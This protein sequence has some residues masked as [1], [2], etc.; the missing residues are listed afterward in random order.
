MPMDGLTIGAAVREINARVAGGR[1]DKINQP[2]EDEIV[3]FIRSGGENYKL[4]LCTNASFARLNL[5]KI[6]K[7]NPLTP[8]S[9]CMLLRKHLTGA[10]VLGLNQDE[11]ERLVRV[12]T[13]VLNDFQEPE[14]RTLILEI[15]GKYS[16]LIFLDGSGRILD[17]IRRVNSLMSR[18]RLIQPGLAYE[19]PPSQGK[20]NPFTADLPH[21]PQAARLL[22]DQYMGLS[23]QAAEEISFRLNESGDGFSAYL[24]Q[25]A[26][27]P[28]DPVLQ[29][30]E[31][32]DP[33]DFFAFPQKRFLPEFQQKRATLSEAI[34]D[35]F[36]L[37]DK[38]CR[39]KERS[40]ELRAKLTGLLEKAE[41]KCAQQEEKLRECADV[42]K[43]RVWGELITANLYQV[44]RGADKTVLPNYYEDMAMTEIPL[45]PALAPNVN[46]QKY[47]KQYNKLKTAAR[48]LTEQRQENEKEIEFFT[49]LLENL[50]NCEND[51]DIAQIRRELTEAGY[52]KAP[53]GKSKP[54]E[55]KPMHF[56]SHD[57][58]DIFVGKNNVQNDELTLRF[59]RPDDLWLHVKEVHGS[60][61]I[62]RSADPDDQ[63]KEE[64]AKLAV[65]YSKG[66]AGEQI[67]VDTA[68]RKFVKKPAGALPGKVI[69]TNQ[70]TYYITVTES[71]IKKILRKE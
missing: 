47:F 14:K 65:W 7:A 45:D 4:L 10:K 19:L 9:F 30:D 55:S 17:A 61:V 18:V 29:V 13:E 1:I 6:Q 46:A 21:S 67:P 8:P 35:Y 68:K 28:L 15:M 32:G 66:R 39:V 24:K 20:E 57:G 34:D 60:H 49:E 50:E 22:A 52:L 48:L 2:E 42:E 38:V 3:L 44:P 36:V 56:L 70:T 71:D 37:K 53:K 51:G 25:Y 69:Y 63:T 31:H 43:Y 54:A 41:K 11:N 62:V 23:R 5:T 59:A 12:E 64:A 58:T 40:H 16:N 33:V 26:S 27:A